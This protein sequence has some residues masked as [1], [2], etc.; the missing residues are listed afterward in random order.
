MVDL[1]KSIA[2]ILKPFA[3]VQAQFPSYENNDF[4]IITIN[5]ISNTSSCEI[6]HEEI[7]SEIVFQIDIW[8]KSESLQ[9]VNA[10]A[11]KVSEA[12][13]K[14]AFRRIIGRG[15]ADE[16]SLMRNMMQFKIEV[17]NITK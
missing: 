5:E 12:M 11:A 14:K 15:F 3:N 8:D 16:S 6:E 10:L 1:N 9:S 13:H 7:S 2:E 17:L 4:P